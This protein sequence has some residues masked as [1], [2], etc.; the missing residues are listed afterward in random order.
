[1]DVKCPGPTLN[2]LLSCMNPNQTITKTTPRTAS[3]MTVMIKI[4]HTLFFF[5]KV[6]PPSNRMNRAQ[7][8]VRQQHAHFDTSIAMILFIGM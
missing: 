2:G 5:S 1:M 8:R 3:T 6:G 4:A 7:Q